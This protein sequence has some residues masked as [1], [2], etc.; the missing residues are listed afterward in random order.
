[1]NRQVIISLT[2]LIILL[3][4]TPAWSGNDGWDLSVDR[5]KGPKVEATFEGSEECRFAANRAE[6]Q[7]GVKIAAC[8]LQDGAVAEAK[9]LHQQSA[10][11]RAHNNRVF[12]DE[13]Q[14]IQD[15]RTR[16]EA[17]EYMQDNKYRR[18]RR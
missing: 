18:G 15:N 11:E 7:N 10:L 12:Y 3:G 1:M 4:S 17:K 9:R 16:D 6:M 8:V 2:A 14:R 5:G 13:V